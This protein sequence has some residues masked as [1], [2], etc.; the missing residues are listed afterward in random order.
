MLGINN[1]NK[2]NKKNNNKKWNNQGNR[3]NA[4]KKNNAKKNNRGNVGNLKCPADLMA[5]KKKLDQDYKEMSAAVNKIV[6][7]QNKISKNQMN[8]LSDRLD[9]SI[10]KYSRDMIKLLDHP[11]YVNLVKCEMAKG[12]NA[13]NSTDAFSLDVID[14]ANKVLSSNIIESPLFNN[15]YLKEYIDLAKTV[16]GYSKQIKGYVNQIG[17]FNEVKDEWIDKLKGF[18]GMF[19]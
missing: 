7:Q 2:N 6:D 3:N 4:A 15:Q 18:T 11:D 5:D 14:V 8:V 1:T 12:Y 10:K 19:S 13:N 9:K 16:V 17:K